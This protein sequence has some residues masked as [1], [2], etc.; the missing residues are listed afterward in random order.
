MA[1]RKRKI[2]PTTPEEGKR[3]V[4]LIDDAILTYRHGGQVDELEQAIGFYFIGRH[5]GWR[6]LLVMHNKRTIRKY[7]ADLGIDI[8]KEFREIGPDADRSIGYRVAS[9]LSN[10]WKAVSGEEKIE[11]RRALD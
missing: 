11:D 6:P 4:D 5:V 7:E 1:K 10:F 9:T 2:P 8:R 3:I